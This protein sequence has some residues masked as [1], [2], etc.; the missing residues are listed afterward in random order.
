M[1][2]KA[3]IRIAA[4]SLVLGVT[5]V[6]CTMGAGGGHLRSASTA[7]PAKGAMKAAE[8]ARKAMADG[9]PELAVQLAEQAVGAM[10]RD[11]GYRTLLGQA[12]L[13]AGRFASAEAS[14]ADSLALDPSDGQ[15]VLSLALARIAQGDSNGA[16]A[17]LDENADRLT[18]SDRGL[19]LAL[20]GDPST[21][22]AVL[23]AAV[24]AGGAD[25]KTRQNLALTYA[26]A[27][28]WNEA[29]IMAEQDVPKGQLTRRLLQWAE[30]AQPRAAS[31]QVASLLGVT[32][33][34][35]DP[36]QPQRLALAPVAPSAEPERLAEAA[37]AAI[38]DATSPDAAP[39]V[40]PAATQ[41]AIAETSPA[42]ADRF[43]GAEPVAAAAPVVAGVLFAPRREVVQPI[44]LAL[45]AARRAAAPAQH[46]AVAPARPGPYVVQIAAFTNPAS[47]RAVWARAVGRSGMLAGYAPTSATVSLGRSSKLHRLS[48]G[49]FETR[50]DANALCERLK[51]S[52]STCFVRAVAGDSPALWGKGAPQRVAAR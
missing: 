26:L 20:S 17:V 28:R 21:A 47:A 46:R 52:G 8:Q 42:V 19:A 30:F 22:I 13:S 23:E 24:R 38:E 36:G 1:N 50:A 4:S 16:R 10:P 11:A 49:G 15:A 41:V 51:A 9:Q 34:L 40:E 18:G 32:P 39:G 14:F 37:P 33:A 7:N 27:G 3:L 12:Y 35:A 31:D 6:G 48:A 43:E 44:P 29:R 2:R 25:A 5:A 45:A